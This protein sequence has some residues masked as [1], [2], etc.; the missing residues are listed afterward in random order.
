MSSTFTVRR[1]GAVGRRAPCG[2]T[3]LY[4]AA[5]QPTRASMTYATALNRNELFSSP[6]LQRD[7]P[8]VLD[9]EEEVLLVLPG[10]AGRFPNVMIATVRQLLVAKVTGGIKGSKISREVRADQVTGI[11][12]RPGLFSR[13]KV[14]VGV[15]RDLAMMPNREADAE[16]FAQSFDQL[17]RT[18]HLPD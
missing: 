2:V 6:G 16:R 12:Y 15:G 11:A 17:L 3:R 13:V 8:K 7:V 9:P 18:G 10:V 1:G 5:V 14:R 4:D